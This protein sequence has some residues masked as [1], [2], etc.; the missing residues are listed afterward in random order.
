MAKVSISNLCHTEPSTQDWLLKGHNIVHTASIYIYIYIYFKLL[1]TK[2]VVLKHFKL[3][4]HF[5]T[6]FSVANCRGSHGD[7]P[8][9]IGQGNWVITDAIP[10]GSL[11]M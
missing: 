8:S 7:N 2:D 4:N 10:N 9:P 6:L 5:A 11:R 3:A 1:S